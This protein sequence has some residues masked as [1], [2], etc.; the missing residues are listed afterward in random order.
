MTK[1]SSSGSTALHAVRVLGI[2]LLLTI[3]GA[4]RAQ[5]DSQQP[6]PSAGEAQPGIFSFAPVIRHA[7]TLIFWQS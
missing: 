5:H 3:A 6:D 7:R 1:N 4:A 2:T